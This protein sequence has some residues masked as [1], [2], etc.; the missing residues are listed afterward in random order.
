MTTI[1]PE[2]RITLYYREGSSDKVYQVSLEPKEGHFVVNFAFG[3]RGSALTTGTKT[4]SPV[5]VETARTIFAKLIGEK[6]AKGYTEGE[7][8]TPYQG[9]PKQERISGLLPQLLNPIDE[10]EMK[11]LINDDKWCTQEKFDG[12]RILIEKQDQAV[13]GINRKGLLV[14]LPLPVVTAA[15]VFKSNFVIDTE[16]VGETFNAFDLLIWDGEDYRTKSYKERLTGLLNLLFSGQQRQIT[17]ADTAWTSREKDRLID[18]LRAANKEGVVFKRIDAPY[19][20]GRP[21]SGGTQLKHK[22]YATASAIVGIVNEQRSVG[23]LLLKGRS[24]KSAGN[25]TIPA[26]QPMP[27]VGS[28]VEIRYL[29]A[30]SESGCLYQPV[31]LGE[32]TDIDKSACTVS[33][34]K[35]KAN[36]TEEES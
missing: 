7:A 23:L 3:R 30:F 12:K 11:N 21:N 26:N 8:G 17:Y 25:V 18:S 29:Y 20:A 32:R 36:P 4:S 28:V 27:A 19:A 5:D 13:R 22:F 33:Q 9:T 1:A 35:Y 24:L 31:Y 15:T 2:S 14:A 6:K 10:A 34:L 16:A